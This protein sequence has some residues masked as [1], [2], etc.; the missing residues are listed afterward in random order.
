MPPSWGPFQATGSAGGDDWGKNDGTR[1]DH[2]VI[3]LESIVER[4]ATKEDI[5]NLRRV[6]GKLSQNMQLQDSGINK[7]TIFFF[8]I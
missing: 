1:M 3:R 7:I 2:R 5:A 6:G 8:Y 4:M